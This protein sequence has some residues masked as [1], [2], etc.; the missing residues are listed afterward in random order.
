MIVFFISVA[1]IVAIS[2]LENEGEDHPKAI[3][4]GGIER[5]RDPIYNVAAFGILAITAALYAF[6]W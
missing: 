1:L 5:E 3:D 4:V 6:F 2:L